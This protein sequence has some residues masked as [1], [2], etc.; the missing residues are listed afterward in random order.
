MKGS[1]LKSAFLKT[2]GILFV[3]LFFFFGRESLATDL[4]SQIRAMI[5]DRNNAINQL[6]DAQKQ[7]LMK[8]AG[9]YDNLLNECAE[10]KN[11]AQWSCM[12]SN[13]KG[14]NNVMNMM[15][16]ISTTGATVGMA[17]GC[18]KMADLL[19]VGQAAQAGFRTACA[20]A[21]SS[22]ETTCE[23]AVKLKK[24][25]M[26]LLNGGFVS[27][28]SSASAQ[29]AGDAALDRQISN[30]MAEL[31][32]LYERKRGED[33]LDKKF[34][35]LKPGDDKERAELNGQ[36]KDLWD[37]QIVP[38]EAELAELK[39]K[40]IQRANAVQGQTTNMSG[41]LDSLFKDATL[42]PA[43]NLKACNDQNAV[44]QKATA[45]LAA[46]FTSMQ[47]N[48]DC[49]DEVKGLDTVPCVLTD[50]CTKAEIQKHCSDP[51]NKADPFCTDTTKAQTITDSQFNNPGLN[52]F[53]GGNQK[54]DGFIDGLDLNSNDFTGD[55]GTTDFASLNEPR[56]GPGV[57][58]GNGGGGVNSA[59]GGGRSGG[60]S[61]GNRP[62]GGGS[63]SEN[64]FGANPGYGTEFT[65]GNN[66]SNKDDFPVGS[67][68]GTKDSSAILLPNGEKINKSTG[69]TIFEKLRSAMYEQVRLGTLYQPSITLTPLTN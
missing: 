17:D 43:V 22:C 67:G 69:K 28:S 5:T 68:D 2:M 1:F 14:I 39:A 12:E 65:F 57:P 47:Q 63:S 64:Q 25:M 55:S 13:D 4:T 34:D 32:S 60:S 46:L 58:G 62:G 48:R 9:D 8:S 42:D 18:S 45:N 27:A 3:T 26:G 36:E 23:E 52:G 51:K 33:G 37:R 38:K 16:A 10:K 59:G 31:D 29:S 44:V 11:T 7:K 24:E 40:K 56:T 50:T 54:D 6:P 53:N 30:V 15:G 21:K 61:N 20:L 41:S 19:K 49:A 35:K 66:S